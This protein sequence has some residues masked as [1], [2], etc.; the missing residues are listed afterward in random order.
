MSDNKYNCI[1]IPGGGLLEDG[2]LPDWTI[3]RLKIALKHQDQTDRLILLS[4][5]TVHKPPP[6]D[7]NGFPIFESRKAA[8]YLLKS[9]VPPESILTETCSYDTIGNAYF[10]RILFTDPL[11]LIRCLV[12]TSDFHMARCQAIFQWIFSLVPLHHEYILSFI[13]TPDA[14]LPAQSLEA[15][16]RREEHSLE[17]LHQNIQRMNT[18]S[19]FQNWLYTAHTAYSSKPN[20]EAL[21]NDELNS[22]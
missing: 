20:T 13:A 15:R 17:K 12:I 16:R 21:S 8:E 10:A 7:E 1:L 18:L 14:G 19:T 22:Y 6:L 4:G 5:G 3:A 9:G 11:A 2:S